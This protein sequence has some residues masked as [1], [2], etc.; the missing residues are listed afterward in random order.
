M[1]EM[2][3]E[4]EAIDTLAASNYSFGHGPSIC[5]WSLRICGYQAL[6]LLRSIQYGGVIAELEQVMQSE[7]VSINNEL[8]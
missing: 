8:L 7:H 4:I 5:L 3:L 6:K 1:T 2:L